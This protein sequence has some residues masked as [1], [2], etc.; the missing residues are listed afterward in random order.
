MS[1]LEKVEKAIEKGKEA[2]LIK[3]AHDK[4]EEVKLA[5][6]AGMGKIGKDDSFNAIVPDM[7]TDEDPKVRAAAAEALGVMKNEHANAHLRYYLEREKDPA[8]IAAMQGA[9]ASL[10]VG[11][12]PFPRKKGRRLSPKGKAGRFFAFCG[13]SP[14]RGKRLQA[15][16]DLPAQPQELLL[17]LGGEGLVQ[18]VLHLADAAADALVQLDGPGGQLQ[19]FQAGVPLH[20]AAGDQPVFLHQLQNARH[21]RA[22]DGELGLDVPLKDLFA[23]VLIQIAYNPPL[24]AG[25][26]VFLSGKGRL[27]HR[28]LHQM[29]QGADLKAQILL[30][31]H[32]F[33]SPMNC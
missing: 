6:I 29:G 10:D 21:R 18:A 7:L 14:V 11:W 22:P 25:G 4:D 2:A 19:L 3:L 9:I 16:A 15:G 23:S 17:F 8:V 33:V 27:V 1:K 26:V 24:H 28:A 13:F 32:D 12:P 20:R 31:F 30:I 5:A